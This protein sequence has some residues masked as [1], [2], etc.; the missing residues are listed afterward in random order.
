MSVLIKGVDMPAVCDECW[1]LDDSGDYPMCR[2]TQ[3][4]RGYTFRSRERRMDKCPLME[5]LPLG[6]IFK[7]SSIKTWK[8]GEPLREEV[9]FRKGGDDE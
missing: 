1:A 4:Q 2:I 3:E 8:P 7:N 5:I 6:D 9:F